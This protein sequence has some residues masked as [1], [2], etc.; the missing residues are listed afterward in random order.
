MT[1]I[2]NWNVPVLA[3][4]DMLGQKGITP[5]AV[6]DGDRIHRFADTPVAERAAKAVELITAVDD[7]GVGVEYT[8]ADGT[9][10][11]TD[12]WF[13]L[14]NDANEILADWYIPP[15][16]EA[17]DRAISEVSAAFYD[18]WEGRSV[19]LVEVN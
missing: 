6:N 9:V 18:A 13:V 17:F 8:D 19:P 1:R 11:R 3:L 14:C 7:A 16:S 10:H 12:L 5:I 15:H 2:R 4:L